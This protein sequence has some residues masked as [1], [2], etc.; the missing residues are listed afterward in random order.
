MKYIHPYDTNS[1]AK[2]IANMLCVYFAFVLNQFARSY[3]NIRLRANEALSIARALSMQ[4][5][6]LLISCLAGRFVNSIN[7]PA[8]VSLARDQPIS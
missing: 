3:L 7:S 4:G 5:C 8:A 6:A 1:W 2:C